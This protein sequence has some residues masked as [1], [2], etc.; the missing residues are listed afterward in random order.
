MDTSKKVAVG[1]RSTSPLHIENAFEYSPPDF[2]VLLCLTASEDASTAFVFI[3][4]IFQSMGETVVSALHD[5]SFTYTSGA[6]FEQAE[7]FTGPAI[8]SED[9]P[10]GLRRR[11]RLYEQP[12]RMTSQSADG[13]AAVLALHAAIERARARGCPTHALSPGTALIFNN[14]IY[15]DAVQGVMHGRNGRIRNI[16]R[17][18]QRLYIFD[19]GARL[20][21]KASRHTILP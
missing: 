20:P 8:R 19:S 12:G 1:A 18:L 5:S 16:Q 21:D 15:R 7:S 11:V 3:E 9:T 4:D 2:V 6:D 13:Q 10:A 14:G 17:W